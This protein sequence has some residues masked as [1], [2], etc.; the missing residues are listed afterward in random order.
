MPSLYRGIEVPGQVVFEGDG[1]FV[2]HLGL[3]N[4]KFGVVG[5]PLVMS[6]SEGLTDKV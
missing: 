4:G 1:G 6:V 3:C 2:V 5:C